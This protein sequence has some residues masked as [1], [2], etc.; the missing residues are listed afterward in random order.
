ML[1]RCNR[2]ALSAW[3]AKIRA[4]EP[5]EPPVV[6]VDEEQP[7]QPGHHR[8]ATASKQKP[9]RYMGGAWPEQPL[10]VFAETGGGTTARRQRYHRSTKAEKRQEPAVQPLGRAVQPLGTPSKD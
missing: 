7:D 2:M 8:P 3:E 5:L 4:E 10:L 6:P 1:D 9:D